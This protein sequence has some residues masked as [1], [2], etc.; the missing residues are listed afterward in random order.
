[1]V[2]LRR[3][4]IKKKNYDIVDDTKKEKRKKKKEQRIYNRCAP[5]FIAINGQIYYFYRNSQF[6]VSA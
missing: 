2:K 1:M 6:S 3:V 5:E 4:C